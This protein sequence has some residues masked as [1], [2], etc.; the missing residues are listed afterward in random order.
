M[1]TGLFAHGFLTIGGKKMSKS[2]GSFITAQQFLQHFEA[3][4]LR[5]YFATKLS[6]KIEDIDLNW[7]DF[8]QKI[9][10]DLVGKVIN[11]ASRTA[12]FIE[13]DFSCQLYHQAIE[14]HLLAQFQKT[15]PNVTQAFQDRDFSQ[16][17]RL[18]MGLADLTNQYIA[19][20]QPWQAIKDPNNQD[21][22]HQTC[23]I[24]L[25]CFR[26]LSILLKPILPELTKKI[27]QFLNL[28]ELS[29]QD[30]HLD[31][32]NHKI[33]P[34]QHLMQRIPTNAADHF[35]MTATT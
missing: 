1:P 10:V 6:Y 28:H 30:L 7:Q 26:D 32:P 15:T 22:V 8:I 27:E 35:S 11:I 29:W 16:A 25:L 23:T 3:E 21:Q 24:A 19:Q 18:I 34:Y 5:Y 20:A 12:K 14:H 31:L 33:Q 4:H 13:R 17:C 9:N 2:R